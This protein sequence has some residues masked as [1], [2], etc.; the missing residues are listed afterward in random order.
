[1]PAHVNGSWISNEEFL[2]QNNWGG[3]S[4][5]NTSNLTEKV[6]MSNTTFVSIFSKIL[7]LKYLNNLNRIFF[8]RMSIA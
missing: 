2:Y 3:I 7:N 4:L 5:L 1:M 8:A 6:L